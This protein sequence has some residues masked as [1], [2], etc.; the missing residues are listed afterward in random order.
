MRR[1]VL[2]T[3]VVALVLTAVV[4]GGCSGD[5]GEPAT[6][7]GYQTLPDGTRVAVVKR[8]APGSD[9]QQASVKID[10]LKPGETVLVREVGSSWDRPQW[11]PTAAVVSR[12]P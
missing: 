8:T 12:A 7:V 5:K 2:M 10:D 6:F 11:M 4:L 1:F 9:A 3:V